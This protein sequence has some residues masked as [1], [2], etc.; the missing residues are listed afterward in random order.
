MSG[1]REQGGLGPQDPANHL[2]PILR[3]PTNQSATGTS[4]SLAGAAAEDEAEPESKKQQQMWGLMGFGGLFVDNFQR[5]VEKVEQPKHKPHDPHSKGKVEWGAPLRGDWCYPVASGTAAAGGD[6]KGG[7]DHKK[8]KAGAAAAAGLRAKPR[9]LAAEAA[10]KAA[11]ARA[12]LPPPASALA[13]T[14][15]LIAGSQAAGIL[16]VTQAGVRLLLQHKARLTPPQLARLAARM[17]QAGM[18]QE[19]EGLVDSSV[20]SGSHQG[21]AVGFVAAALTGGFRAWGR[22]VGVFSGSLQCESHVS[23]NLLSGNGCSCDQ[24]CCNCCLEAPAVFNSK[25]PGSSSIGA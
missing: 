6:D 14:V 20:G 16:D 12:A 1:A 4:G 19:I 18:F 11:Q 22:G 15:W 21:Q 9:D 23:Q 24:V 7:K 2:P 17:A 5:P 3:P 10:E 13:L 8:A 25:S